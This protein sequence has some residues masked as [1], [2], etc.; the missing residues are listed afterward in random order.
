MTAGS[1][2]AALVAANT[3]FD[4]ELIGRAIQPTD[5]NLRGMICQDITEKAGAFQFDVTMG[6][7][8][9]RKW[10]GE[11]QQNNMRQIAGSAIAEPYEKLLRVSA[12]DV[13]T[14]KTNSI[15]RNID[16]FFASVGYDL[17]KLTIDAAMSASILGADGQPLLSA[18]HPYSSSTGNNLTTS[19]LGY[20]VKVAAREAMGTWKSEDGK[21]IS[22]TPTHL[23]CSK[24]LEKTAREIES[25]DRIVGI[26]ASGVEASTSV[27]AAATRTN[28][29]AGECIVV[30]TP[31]L[32]GTQF[33]YA[34]LST[35]DKPVFRGV[36]EELHPE[37][38]DKSTDLPKFMNNEY[39]YG[40][41]G[42]MTF[43][44]GAWQLVYGRRTTS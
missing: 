44:P 41:E 33:L 19:D 21:F 34:D 27:L 14:N 25:A 6:D 5:L 42:I 9:L 3:Y 4:S 39:L 36:A 18:S 31:L 15:L 26:N 12:V 38:L 16:R 35:G 28:V 43:F 22:K 30:S 11:R 13:K 32:T 10:Y 23:F 1:Q 17:D 2:S 20:A 7:P 24:A 8:A 40:V 29:F 37:R